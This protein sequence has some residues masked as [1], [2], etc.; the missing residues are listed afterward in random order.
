[1]SSSDEKIK[2]LINIHVSIS[3]KHQK[4]LK[5]RKRSL[6]KEKEKGQL[7]LFNDM[8]TRQKWK[9]RCSWRT[10]TYSIQA[11][12]LG[13]LTVIRKRPKY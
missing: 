7:K 3:E 5:K 1:M 8:T 11:E 4:Y 6:Q 2:F 10:E 13:A 9:S 12:I